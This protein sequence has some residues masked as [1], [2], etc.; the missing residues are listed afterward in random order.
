M[1]ARPHAAKAG[2][3]MWQSLWGNI[4]C[5]EPI[6]NSMFQEQNTSMHHFV[7]VV[8][9]CLAARPRPL[10]YCNSVET[11]GWASIIEAEETYIGGFRLFFFS[12]F[13]S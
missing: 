2:D 6:G 10:A 5:E 11:M 1:S 12:F 13:F 3:T 8:L 7:E 9:R 4:T